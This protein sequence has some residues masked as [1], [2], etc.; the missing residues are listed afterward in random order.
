[1]HKKLVFNIVS[2]ILF[3]I[4]I[5]MLAPLAWAI[6]DDPVSA[7]SRAFAITILV[8]ITISLL[9]RMNLKISDEDFENISAKDGLAIV[10]L[11]WISISAFSALPFFLS[12]VTPSY[13]DAFFE[14]V[15]GF[16]TT[17][18]TIM[19]QIES[20]P[21]G[22]LFWRSM[23]HWLGGMGIIV[24]SVA[25][26][27]ALG[28]G[29][30]KLY[31]AEAPGPTAERIRP[32]MKET[33]KSLWTVYF[34]L[35]A[36][37]TVLLMTGGM[38]LFDALAHTF[39]TMA[40]GGFSTKTASIGAY[41][42]YI[43]WVVVGFMFLA[44]ANF[45]LHYQGMRGRLGMYVRDDEF[46]T[47]S[48][49]ILTGIIVFTLVLSF[50]QKVF[51]EETLRQAAFQVVSI[52]TT[53]GYTTADFNLWP[54]FLKF[55][56]I[57]LMFIGGCAGST[58]GGLKVV[59]VFVAVKS[60]FKSILQAIFPNAVIPVRVNKRSVPDA[61]ILAAVSYFV[62][63]MFLFA[64]GIVFLTLTEKV[65]LVTAMSASIATLSNIGPGLGKV[66]AM[67]NYAWIS[68]PG[69]VMLSFLM[70]AGRLELFSI[71]VL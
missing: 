18:A 43:Q 26:L 34:I 48:A 62:I 39:G 57:M 4:C 70:L 59:R 9:A 54:A 41:G 45:M 21:R 64:F 13:I 37:E 56:L 33:A 69:K 58:G 65:D 12:G 15:S 63:Y 61:Y 32:K 16:T 51:S 24:L 68:G 31:R 52:M 40:T 36:V 14:T 55:V 23:T 47:Y 3:V 35:T 28:S 22:I 60:G 46:R 66:G 1:M 17:G 42:P 27:P 20:L 38:P 30:Y 25:L 19:T 6:L 44:G 2:R 67:E 7:E 29:A 53:T 50:E 49:L 71:L 5:T 10:G 11:S 8:G